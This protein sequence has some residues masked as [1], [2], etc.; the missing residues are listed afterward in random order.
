VDFLYA[1]DFGCIVPGIPH[2]LLLYYSP[3][4]PISAL[5][6]PPEAAMKCLV[7]YIL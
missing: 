7:V 3:N 2:H 6:N 5:L 4:G 1:D